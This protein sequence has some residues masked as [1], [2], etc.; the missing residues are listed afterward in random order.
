MLDMI[1]MEHDILTGL[2]WDGT[3]YVMHG[4]KMDWIEGQL[5]VLVT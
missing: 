2:G 5:R 4:D 1:Y 3:G